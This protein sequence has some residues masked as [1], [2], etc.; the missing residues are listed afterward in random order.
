[1]VLTRIQLRVN[2]NLI[3]KASNNLPITLQT[4]SRHLP[5]T[6]NTLSRPSIHLLRT[7]NYISIPLKDA[8]PKSQVTHWVVVVAVVVV[9]ATL[10][11]VLL[12]VRHLETQA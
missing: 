7:F 11:V 12:C 1:M 9:A 5:D 3:K 6:I 8:I 4:H 2:S 10:V